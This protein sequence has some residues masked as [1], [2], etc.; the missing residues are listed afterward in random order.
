MYEFYNKAT[1]VDGIILGLFEMGVHESLE[2]ISSTELGF[3][4]DKDRRDC[5]ELEEYKAWDAFYED[6][7]SGFPLWPHDYN[8][9]T[10]FAKFDGHWLP[11]RVSF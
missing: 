4:I 1:A 7:Y 11:I 8:D 10:A 2:W 9:I 3:P 5:R 6:Q